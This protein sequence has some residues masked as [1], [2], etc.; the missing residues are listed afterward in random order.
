MSQALIHAAKLK[1]EIRL[2]QAISD[3]GACL[4]AQQRVSFKNIQSSALPKGID[5]V[6]FTEELNRDGLHQHKSW[7]P[8]STRLVSILERIQ[9]YAGDILIGGSQ[10]LIACGMWATFRVTLQVAIGFLNYFDKLSIFLMRIGRL[11]SIQGELVNVFSTSSEIQQSMCEYLIIMA[12]HVGSFDAEFQPFKEEL[13]HWALVIEKKVQV[14]T[15]QSQASSETI[16]SKSFSLFKRRDLHEERK[17]FLQFLDDLSPDQAR[18]DLN[19]RHQRKKGTCSWILQHDEYLMWKSETYSTTLLVSRHLGSGKTVVLANIVADLVLTS[20]EAG[21]E[22]PLGEVKE[23]K[24]NLV[25]YFFYQPGFASD[26]RTVLGSIAR[27]YFEQGGIT[28]ARVQQISKELRIKTLRFA[29]NDDF[30]RFMGAFLSMKRYYV[31]LDG[32]DEFC[33]PDTEEV[34]MGLSMLAKQRQIHICVSSRPRTIFESRIEQLT[35]PDHRIPMTTPARFAEIEDYIGREIQE[36]KHIH[37]L[38]ETLEKIIRDRLVNVAQGMYLWVALQLE[39]VLPRYQ[40]RAMN[41]VDLIQ[42]LIALPDELPR[43]FDEALAHISDT[44][45]GSRIFQCTTAARRPLTPTQL[46]VVLNVEP[47]NDEWNPTTMILDSPEWV[48]YCA[49]G[50]LEVE[51]SN[52]VQYIHHSVEFHLII[53]TYSV[54]TNP[55]CFTMDVADQLMGSICV[56]YLNYSFLQGR[57]IRYNGR[58]RVTQEDVDRT[59]RSLLASSFSAKLI[60]RVRRKRIPES[61]NVD[62]TR[63]IQS[64]SQR[65][66]REQMDEISSFH[67]YAKQEWEFHTK[68]YPCKELGWRIVCLWFN[69]LSGKWTNSTFSTDLD[70]G[71][72]REDMIELLQIVSQPQLRAILLQK[73]SYD[74]FPGKVFELSDPGLHASQFLEDFAPREPALLQGLPYNAY[75]ENTFEVGSPEVSD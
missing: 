2:A 65:K 73:V 28:G 56:T 20:T 7:K 71:F 6:K 55:Y 9:I 39:A 23:E 18:I 74:A 72:T 22:T 33:G 37:M 21:T 62:I 1:P 75:P 14:L 50:L 43:I 8:Y 57:M 12:N 64:Y 61:N 66:T 17:I 49:G 68:I 40:K 29:E 38:D 48:G 10:N 59:L 53:D 60:A 5:V 3:Y 63:V 41:E 25:A 26:S 67:D 13:Q 19:W 70:R 31:L 35:Q 11:S 34:L 15:S 24:N 46:R 54:K 27:Q 52:I 51:E 32:L 36:R 47:G 44:R 45:Y 30:V 69:L 16:F 42:R 4:D 58:V